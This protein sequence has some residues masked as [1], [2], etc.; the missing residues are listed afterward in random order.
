MRDA[1]SAG[2]RRLASVSSL[3]DQPGFPLGIVNPR[4]NTKRLANAKFLPGFENRLPTKH[5]IRLKL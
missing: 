2:L 5:L 1:F 4:T 3:S